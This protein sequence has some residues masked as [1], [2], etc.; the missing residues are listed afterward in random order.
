MPASVRW[1]AAVLVGLALLGAA[2]PD[3]PKGKVAPDFRRDVLP[4]LEAKCVRCHDERSRKG[5]ADLHSV[6]GLLKGGVSG[7]S[8]KP[9]EPAKS[10]LVDLIYYREMPPKRDKNRVT[11]AELDV[12]RA[13]IEAGAKE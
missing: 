9:G 8:I 2:E 7:P 3:A 11:D 5:G 13:W 10:L 1:S 6:V 4:I 12:I